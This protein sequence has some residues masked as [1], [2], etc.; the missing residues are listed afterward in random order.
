MFV[1][2]LIQYLKDEKIGNSKLQQNANCN[3]KTKK[4]RVL[5]LNVF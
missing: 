2:I 3:E 1:Q 5:M 4:L